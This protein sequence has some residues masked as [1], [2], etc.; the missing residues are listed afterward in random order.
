VQ[1]ALTVEVVGAPVPGVGVVDAEV[2]DDE[3]DEPEVVVSH[4]AVVVDD[5]EAV[6]GVVVVIVCVSVAVGDAL[7]EL[8]E[9]EL[10]G[11]TER[12]SDA[13]LLVLTLGNTGCPQQLEVSQLGPDW[14]ASS[15]VMRIRPFCLYEAECSISP[16]ICLSN[17]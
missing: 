7:V 16:T 4:P 15:N 17:G 12:G 2:L 11:L 13:E 6:L 10:E 3:D 1:V 5:A 14:G 9:D 8:V